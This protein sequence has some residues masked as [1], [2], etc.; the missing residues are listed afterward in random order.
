MSQYLPSEVF[1]KSPPKLLIWEF[2]HPQIA[3]ANSTQLRRLV[4]LVDNGCVGK[5]PLLAN[6]VQLSS[7]DDL[8]EVLFNGGGYIIPAKSRELIVDL[9]FTDPAVSEILG[10]AWYLDGKHE[11]LRVRM[12]D[13]TRVNGRFVLELNREP[14]Y[15]EQPLI[16]FRVQIVTPLAKPTTV[17]A[18][19]CRS[20]S[21]AA[22][23]IVHR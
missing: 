18:K 23:A 6:D 9:Q 14:D 22:V 7:G 1:Q 3:V 17:A 8:T 11:L 20:A 10:E 2:A 13:Y 5:E 4:P 12:N 16:D 19:L 15:A 21:T